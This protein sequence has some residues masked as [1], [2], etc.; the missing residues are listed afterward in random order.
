MLPNQKQFR[1]QSGSSRCAVTTDRRLHVR[2]DATHAPARRVPTTAKAA[3]TAVA[4]PGVV[5]THGLM[6]VADRARALGLGRATTFTA[7]VVRAAPPVDTMNREVLAWAI[8]RFGHNAR[9]WKT[10][11]RPCAA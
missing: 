8:R 5:T 7:R 9:R 11:S 10:P 6:G 3:P 2:L 1:L 4:H